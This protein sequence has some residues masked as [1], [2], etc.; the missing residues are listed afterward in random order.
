LIMSRT[1]LSTYI[2]NKFIHH[3]LYSNIHEFTVYLINT[4]ELDIILNNI[5]LVWF[6]FKNV[7]NFSDFKTIVNITKKMNILVNH[8]YNKNNFNHFDKL[9][10]FN[11]SLLQYAEQYRL[12]GYIKIVDMFPEYFTGVL[13]HSQQTII[14]K[15]IRKVRLI[16]KALNKYFI[17]DLVGYIKD[18]LF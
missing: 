14:N 15:S 4:K 11:I 16:N 8:L 2:T 17:K 3:I 12:N 10:M 18:Y 1:Y 13:E 9:H 6:E 7:N 5:L